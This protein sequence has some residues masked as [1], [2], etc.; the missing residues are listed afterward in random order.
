MRPRERILTALALREPDRVPVSPDLNTLYC[1][2]IA[3]K[4]FWEV[5]INNDPPLWKLIIDIGRKQGFDTIIPCCLG[6]GPEDVPS[7]TE[8]VEETDEYKVLE[9]KYFTKKGILTEQMLYPAHDSPWTKKP[10]IE[11]IEEDHEKVVSMFTNP[12]GKDTGYFIEVR[13][14]LGEDGIVRS[15]GI[16]VPTD[17]LRL[18]RLSLLQCIY[19]T[20]FLF[21]R[22]QLRY[23]KSITYR[24]R[25]ICAESAERCWIYLHPIRILL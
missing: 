16:T 8:T 20:T 15:G 11:N 18:C 7:A 9:T 12:C 3:G 4:P 2:R 19:D 24:A 14:Y 13:R 23:V 6:A 10:L 21:C 22:K 25:C 17:H 5:L 1:C